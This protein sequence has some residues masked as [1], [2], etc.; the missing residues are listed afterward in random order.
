MISAAV[1]ALR[2][3]TQ[4]QESTGSEHGRSDWRALLAEATVLAL[5]MAHVLVT[6]AAGRRA[7]RTTQP[8]HAST[9][10]LCEECCA[11]RSFVRREL[12]AETRRVAANAGSRQRDNEQVDLDQRAHALR[13]RVIS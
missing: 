12:A 1:T 7:R 11:R 2:T 9:L 13:L 5:T 4:L 8:Q 10:C 3:D 6:L